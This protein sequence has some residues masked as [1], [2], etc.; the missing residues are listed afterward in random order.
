MF[1]LDVVDSDNFLDMPSS[2]RCLYYDLGMR[3]DDDGFVNP[4]KVIRLT[5]ATDDDLKILITKNFVIPFQ[6]GVVVITHWK[7]NNQL[8]GDRYKPT[9]YQQEISLLLENNNEYL[10]DTPVLHT[11][12]MTIGKPSIGKV[13]LGKVSI[14]KDI[15]VDFIKDF[16]AITGKRFRYDKANEGNLHYWL[17]V[18]SMEE[19]MIAVKLAH[20]ADDWWKDKLTPVLLLRQRNKNG[21]CDY[22][23]DLLNK[24][25][26]KY[27]I[28]NS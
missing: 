10:I 15:Y 19:I 16:N 26:G 8:R 24:Y 20:K 21:N 18:Y 3:A 27:E 25:E 1:S 28:N 6:T 5:T 2:S 12:G 11:T 14:G 4:K 13:R 7:R 22:I 23:G 9:M 17:S